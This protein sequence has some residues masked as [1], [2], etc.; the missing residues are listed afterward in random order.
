MDKQDFQLLID[1]G[2]IDHVVLQSV[3]GGGW[4]VWSYGKDWSNSK[5]LKTARGEIRYFQSLDTAYGFVRGCG[6]KPQIVV[7]GGS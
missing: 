7:D 2:A 1:A 6:W 4:A 5:T 3:A